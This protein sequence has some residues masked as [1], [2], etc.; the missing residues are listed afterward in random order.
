LNTEL[1]DPLAR[2][3]ASRH[4][5]KIFEGNLFASFEA[6]A[7]THVNKL[8]KEVENSAVAGLKDRAK[9]RGEVALEETRVSI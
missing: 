3:I 6:R 8:L 7:I 2:S 4:W 1:I 9:S 5:A